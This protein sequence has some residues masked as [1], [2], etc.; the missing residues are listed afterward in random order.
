MLT[1][2]ST[3][4]C[5]PTLLNSDDKTTLPTFAKLQRESD[6]TD[7]PSNPNAGGVNRLINAGGGAST[8]G[9]DAAKQVLPTARCVCLPPI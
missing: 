9:G 2:C 3:S 8:A 7:Q 6:F 1:M 5:P 4:E